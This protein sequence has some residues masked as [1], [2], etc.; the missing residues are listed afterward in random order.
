MSGEKC[1]GFRFEIDDKGEGLLKIININFLQSSSTK[2]ILGNKI[3][4]FNS[5]YLQN[6]LYLN[7]LKHTMKNGFFIKTKLKNMSANRKNKLSYRQCY[8]I[9]KNRS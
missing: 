7:K 4:V 6:K 9:N 2:N 1:G 8:L 3:T 5:I